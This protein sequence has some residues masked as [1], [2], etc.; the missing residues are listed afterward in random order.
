MLLNYKLSNKEI[1]QE[2]NSKYLATYLSNNHIE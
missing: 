2:I 1:V